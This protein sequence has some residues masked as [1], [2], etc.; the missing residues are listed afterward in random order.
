MN[1]EQRT[2]VELSS[3]MPPSR[4]KWVVLG[5]TTI[6]IGIAVSWGMAYFIMGL[7]Y[8]LWFPEYDHPLLRQYLTLVLSMTLL[9]VLMQVIRLV[10]KPKG[11]P[12]PLMPMIDA[13]RRMSKGDFNVN[14]DSNSRHMGHFAPLVSSF[15]EMAFELNQIEIMRQEFISNVSHEIQSPLTSI[16]GF[17]RALQSDQLTPETRRHYLDIIETESKRLSRMSDNLLKL[18]SLE[19]KHH[20][21]EPKSYRL[22]RQLRRII[23]SCEPLWQEK[24]IH[25]D[26]E[27]PEL[28]VVADEDLMNQVWINLL[29]NSIKFT[30]EGGKIR[31]LLEEE[32]ERLRIE[33]IDNGSGIPETAL[34]HLF[35]RF[36]KADKARNRFGNGSGSGLGL[37][38]VKKIID[39]HGGE[40]TAHSY[41]NESTTFR[42]MLSASCAA[43]SPSNPT[44]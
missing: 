25:M 34:P 6:H 40:I 29:H 7:I 3:S 43:P 5:V 2:D 8:R 4:W 11:H 24:S 39:M 20:P 22:D 26:V 19:S 23:L 36:F 32:N 12:M 38:I 31:V 33:F 14:L 10:F 15:N 1:D 41:P 42:V 13:M 16:S 28:S 17:A 27:L 37:S 9:F 30:S 21:F 44:L 18:T 35:E